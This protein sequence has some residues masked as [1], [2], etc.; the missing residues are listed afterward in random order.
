MSDI[1]AQIAAHEDEAEAWREAAQKRY[2]SA[3]KGRSDFRKAFRD[4]RRQADVYGVALLMIAEGCAD[5]KRVAREAIE[6]F[7]S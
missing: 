5:P 6:K 4:K 2:E 7:K 3:V 1:N